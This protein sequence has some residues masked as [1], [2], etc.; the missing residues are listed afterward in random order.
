MV[1][2][3]REA[4]RENKG[5]VIQQRI[6]GDLVF[7]IKEIAL[8]YDTTP[9]VI[10]LSAFYIFLSKYSRQKD[11]IVGVP[12][13]GRP[14]NELEQTM[15]MFLETLPIRV[16]LE[17]GISARGFINIV[18]N[19]IANALNNQKYPLEYMLKSVHRKIR[20]A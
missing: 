4:K 9:F 14:Y 3:K 2:Y 7:K 10:S 11:L 15:G 1:D 6:D 18:K 13:V 17:K 19:K 12:T 16:Q 5:D 8:E 20:R